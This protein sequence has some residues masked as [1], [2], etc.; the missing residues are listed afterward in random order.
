MLQ[1]MMTMAGLAK[2]KPKS[3][4]DCDRYEYKSVWNAVSGT[5]DM[6]KI[7]VSG[8]LD[9]EEHERSARQTREWLQ[10]HV[11]VNS[12][13]VVL[14]IGAGFGRVGEVLAPICKRWIGTD[15]SENMVDTMRRR[16]ARFDNVEIIATN[17]FDL[18]AIPSA[19]VDMAYCTTVFMHLDEWERYKYVVESLRVLKPGGRFIADNFNLCS[20]DGWKIFMEHVRIP[21]GHRPPHISRMSTPQEIESYFKRAG[22]GRIGQAE[23]GWMTITYGWKPN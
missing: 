9:T 10:Q 15:V 22:F 1:R 4:E 7:A 21:P 18:A 8:T 12:D 16:L 23:L 5:D 14:E 11:G 2:Q 6:A 19:S 13:D 20:D 3:W 17:G